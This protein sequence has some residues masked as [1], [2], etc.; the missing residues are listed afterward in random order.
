MKSADAHLITQHAETGFGFVG[1]YSESLPY[2]L[3][4]LTLPETLAFHDRYNANIPMYVFCEDGRADVTEISYR[5]FVRACYEIPRATNLPQGSLASA[6]KKPV[7]A[8]IALS[9]TL[10]YQTTVAGL[11]HAGYIPFPISHRNTVEAIANLI[12]KQIAITF[13]QPARL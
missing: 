5:Q 13:L 2:E 1:T 11:M 9:D 8:V 10:V 12:R 6:S 4:S 7:V 3:P